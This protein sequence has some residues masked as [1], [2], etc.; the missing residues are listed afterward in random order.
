[1]GLKPGTEVLYSLVSNSG[2]VVRT[3]EAQDEQL[4]HRRAAELRLRLFRS[5][6]VVEELAPRP[7]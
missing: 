6:T 1:M 5:T 2:R 3:Y 4:S 7:E